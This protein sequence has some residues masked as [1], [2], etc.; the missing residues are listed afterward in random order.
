V[1]YDTHGCLTD[2]CVNLQSI[3]ARSYNIRVIL[4]KEKQEIFPPFL[5]RHS[6]AVLPKVDYGTPRYGQIVSSLRTPDVVSSDPQQPVMELEG[7]NHS[8][9]AWRPCTSCLTAR[10]K[11]AFSPQLHVIV[12]YWHEASSGSP[13]SRRNRVGRVHII[14]LFVRGTMLA[15]IY[16]DLTGRPIRMKLR[17]YIMSLKGTT[18]YT[19]MRPSAYLIWKNT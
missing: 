11:S 18:N 4:S 3:S 13:Y 10:Y 1:Q 15:Y 8:G 19:I 16:H 12:S 5:R 9:R 6:V 17:M 14:A 2:R 7:C